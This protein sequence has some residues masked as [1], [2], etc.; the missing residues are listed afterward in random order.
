MSYQKDRDE[1][2][3]VIVAEISGKKARA[4]ERIGTMHDPRVGTD[5][6]AVAL[7][8]LILRNA[9]TIQRYAINRCNREVQPREARNAEACARRIK[10]ACEPWGIKAKCKRR[11]PGLLCQ[12]DSALWPPQ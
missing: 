10:E 7:A 12:A 11:P 3:G 5:T 4:V 8:R 9:A 6:K 2:V 1:F